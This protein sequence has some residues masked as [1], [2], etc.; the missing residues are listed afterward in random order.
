[1]LKVVLTEYMEKT[2]KLVDLECGEVNKNNAC[3]G[4][5]SYDFM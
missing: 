3:W 1:M 5:P 4:E 2:N